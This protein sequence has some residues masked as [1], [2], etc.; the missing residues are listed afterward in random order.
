MNHRARISKFISGALLLTMFQ[1]AAVTGSLTPAAIAGAPNPGN[2]SFN[3]STSPDAAKYVDGAYIIDAGATTGSATKQTIAQGI[4]PYGLIYALV[5]AGIPVEWIINPDKSAISQTTGNSGTDFAYDCDGPGGAASKNYK[6]G[7]FLIKKD[8]A[9]QAAALVTTWK[10]KGVVVDGPCT[11]ALPNLPVYATIQSWP[12]VALDAQNGAVAV[13][14]FQNAEIPQGSLTDPLNPPAYRF[15]APSALTPCDDMYVMPHADPTYATHSNLINFVKNGGDFY[16]SCHAVSIVENMTD[17]TSAN[18]V[19]NFLSTNGLVNYDGHSQ[20]SPAYT[21]Y[22]TSTSAVPALSYTGTYKSN[23]GLTDTKTAA[24]LSNDYTLPALAPGDPIAQFLGVTDAAQ[25]QGS[26]Q[27]FMP[28]ETSRWRPTTQVV[29]Y[30]QSQANSPDVRTNGSVATNGSTGSVTTSK[31]AAASV[32]Y[33]PA[34]GNS[35]YGQVMYVGGHSSNKGTVDDVATQR[36]F[37]NFLLFAAVSSSAVPTA[38][39]RT[40]SV[41]MANLGTPKIDKNQ[42]I[43]VSGSATGGSGVFRYRWSST[44]YNRDNQQVVGVSSGSFSDA[45]S[46][47]TTYTP[48]TSEIVANCNL[49]LTAIDSCGRFA[50]GFITVAI[51]PTTDV[52]ISQEV[53]PTAVSGVDFTSTVRIANIGSAVAASTIFRTSKPDHA[54]F[55]G[56]PV[57]TGAPALS[58][59]AIA[60]DGSSLSCNLKDLPAGDSLTVT[61]Q[62]TPN[63]A[64]TIASVVQVTTLSVE[65]DESNNTDSDI[66]TVAAASP[67]ARLTL[68]KTPDAQWVKGGGNASFRIEVKNTSTGDFEINNINLAENFTT[69]GT[70]AC[71]QGGNSVFIGG[72]QLIETLSVGSSW[73]A[74]CLIVG[75]TGSGANTL[76]VSSA[77]YFDGSATVNVP[78]TTSSVVAITKDDAM[79]TF[80]KTLEPSSVIPGNKIKYKFKVTNSG[81]SKSGVNF[82][83]NLPA[84]LTLV[85]NSASV[86]ST[87]ISGGSAKTSRIILLDKFYSSTVGTGGGNTWTS[88]STG[89]TDRISI[90]GSNYY[91]SIGSDSKKLQ[92]SKSYS[93]KRNFTIGANDADVVISFDCATTNGSGSSGMPSVALLVNGTVKKSQNCTSSRAS[94]ESDAIPVS[95]LTVGSNEL[96]I[97]VTCPSSNCDNWFVTIDDVSIIAG[98]VLKESFNT[99]SSSKATNTSKVCSSKSTTSGNQLGWGTGKKLTPGSTSDNCSTISSSDTGT[100]FIDVSLPSASFSSASLQ[101][102]YSNEAF[103]SDSYFRVGLNASC[104]SPLLDWSG[105]GITAHGD[106]TKN[107]KADS[108]SVISLTPAGNMRIYLCFKGS[109]KITIDDVV[110]L[111]APLGTATETCLNVN[112]L[113]AFNGSCATGVSNPYTVDPG[114]TLEITFQALIDSEFPDP[115]AI[116]IVNLAYLTTSDDRS[117]KVYA[118]TEDP[119]DEN[120]LVITKT[121]DSPTVLTGELPTFTYQLQNK[122]DIKLLNMTVVDNGCSPITYNGGALPTFINARA[123]LTFKCTPANNAAVLVQVES[124][125]VTAIATE[126][127]TTATVAAIIADG[128]SALTYTATQKLLIG[129]VSPGIQL[130]SMTPE[131]STITSGGKV[132]YTY[133]VKNSGTIGLSKVKINASNCP[134]SAYFS[135]DSNGNGILD[136]TETWTYKC[137]TSAITVAQTTESVTATGYNIFNDGAITSDSKTV[138]VSLVTPAV[139]TLTKQIKDGSSGTLASSLLNLGEGNDVYSVV[140]LTATGGPISDIVISDEGC[141]FS[142]T[143]NSGDAGS[144]G[145]LGDGETWIFSCHAG[146]LYN[147]ETTTAV[148]KG[149]SPDTLKTPVTSNAVSTYVEVLIPGL[150]LTIE[151]RREYVLAGSSNTYTYK[152]SNTGGANVTF[153]GTDNRCA[154]PTVFNGVALAIGESRTATCSYILAE[155]TE[156]NFGGSATYGSGNTYIA[157]TATVNVFAVHPQF[158]VVKKAT[159]Y[160]GSS[161]TETR[162]VLASTVTAQAGDRIV[163]TYYLSAETGTGASKIDGLNAIVRSSF[164][165][166]DCGSAGLIATTGS[167]GANIGDLN[168]TGYIDPREEWVYTCLARASLTGA[169]GWLRASSAPKL[170]KV[171]NGGLTPAPKVASLSATST[172][173]GSA[174]ATSSVNSPVTFTAV[175]SLDDPNEVSPILT[176]TGTSSVTINVEGLTNP[177]APPGGNE[178]SVVTPVITFNPNF[179][180]PTATTQSG[181]GEVTLALNTFKRTGFTFKGWS[182]LA[183]GP[184]QIIDGG[185]LTVTESL[186]LYAIW[187]ADAPVVTPTPTAGPVT[188]TFNS[189]C[190]PNTVEKQSNAGKV[191]LNSNTFTCAGSAFQGWSSTPT[192]AVEYADQALFNFSAATSLYAIWKKVDVVPVIK[193]GEYRFEVFFGMN[194]VAITAAEKKNIAGHVATIKRKAGKSASINVVVEGWVQPNPKPG[195]IAY[196]SKYRAEHV[197]KMMAALGLKAKYKELYKGLG[198]DNMPKARHASVIVTWT[199]KK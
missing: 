142:S 70:L 61:Y 53:P 159:V 85:N 179:S 128:G 125:T 12:R 126:D 124:G 187:E 167:S 23:Y 189:N 3:T 173:S 40:P 89:S 175:S 106:V 122:G 32:L 160:V 62:L 133:V 164:A 132:N 4:K 6:S 161:T 166:S 16:A 108:S 25:Q 152:V 114:N 42:S 146:K 151:P 63:S 112:P 49:T 177:P 7:A 176:L 140:T 52:R 37:F 68:S 174:Y 118:V 96:E 157:D 143:P 103:T 192:G 41:T 90:S 121:V 64:G 43:N 28:N 180:G 134:T 150:L 123:T 80:E 66:T 56:T 29:V 36:L 88:S 46:A 73:I 26:E 19:M 65:T 113:T 182:R 54:S 181:S 94:F 76:S 55:T 101:L 193:K 186:T 147:S 138:T 35:N 30:D 178:P 48:P 119:F 22:E 18:K 198:P 72:V 67:V 5:K 196:L 38:S 78:A 162:T 27:I 195:N 86:K 92:D 11:S 154:A 75:I 9:L 71:S 74:D 50:F 155:D 45:T 168:E 10:A 13:A 20:G 107:S 163:F 109:K 148:A 188:V 69:G 115:D 91:M 21:I 156:S 170:A 169:T 31:G 44:C 98:T 2:N 24:V 57:L 199:I 34:F 172:L 60:S 130:F 117:K 165:D 111:G 171:A 139:I 100:Y 14:Y 131:T 136:R 141:A 79:L 47:S 102:R 87:R 99:L 93:V 197:A 191:K 51:S 135:G 83:D 81:T 137:T 82:V 15:V 84:G 104:A 129:V 120:P 17:G 77:T 183:T 39:D 8:F 185:K 97:K 158:N 1:A 58:S 105:S 33:G 194:S 184:V 110:I 116:G 190:A 149:K 127:S 145:K 153:T 144:D 59:C 95:A